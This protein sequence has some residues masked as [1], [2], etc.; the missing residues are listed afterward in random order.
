MEKALLTLHVTKEMLSSL[1]KKLKKNNTC[2]VLSESMWCP[3]LLLHN[4]YIRFGM[5]LHIQVVGIPIDT[6]CA[7][8]VLL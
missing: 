5:K 1:W 7:P 2:M 6:N 8:L 3:D 4:T